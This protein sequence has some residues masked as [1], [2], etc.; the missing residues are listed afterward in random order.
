MAFNCCRERFAFHLVVGAM[1]VMVTALPLAHAKEKTL[2]PPTLSQEDLDPAAFEQSVQGNVRP[3]E[4]KF[5]PRGPSSVVWTPTSQLH[6]QGVEF[7]NDRAVGPRHLRIGFKQPQAVGSVLV[8]GGGQLSVL[9][10]DAPYP[11]NLDDD[12]QWL[13]ATRLTAKGQTE[14]AIGPDDL[15]LWDLPP[16]TKTRA[17]RFTHVVKPADRMTYGVLN[18]VCLFRDRLANVS[19]QA[20]LASS[21][22]PEALRFLQD[23]KANG[24]HTWDNGE[25]G[26][27]A[28]VSP[29]N[30]EWVLLAWPEAVRL[31]GV[32]FVW[33][34]FSAVEVAA[35]AGPAET[36]PAAAKESDWKPLRTETELASHYPARLGFQWI[37]FAEPV[38]TRALRLRFTAPAAP[39]HPH[40][41]GKVQ[42]GKRIWLDELLA[43]SPLGDKPVSTALL[44]PSESTPPPIPIRF[45]LPEAGLVT[46]VIEDE[47]GRRVRNL[48]SETPYPAGENVAYWDGSDD[49]LRDQDAA[50]HG[51]YHI[52]TRLVPTGK[53]RV[54][55]LWHKPL[56]LH[57]EMSVYTS[58][59]PAWVTEDGTGCWLT[60]HT[61]PTSMAYIPGTK[62]A[63]GKPLMMMGAFV[64]EGGHGLQWVQ[65]DGTKVGG[66]GRIGGT[67]TGAQSLAVDNGERASPDYL[68][69]AGSI[70]E[71]ELRLTAKTRNL[72]DADILKYKLGDDP[73]TKSVPASELPPRLEGFDGGEKKFV[74][75]GMAAHDGIIVCSL[76]R[77]NELLFISAADRR[78]IGKA[79]VKNPRGVAI[80]PDGC[81]LVLSGKRLLRYGPLSAIAQKLADPT[82]QTPLAPP[83]VVIEEG[84]EDPRQV[85]CRKV[86]GPN[87]Y[88]ISDRG[89]ENRVRV[90]ND[91]GQQIRVYGKPG[92]PSEGI[93]DPL[94]MNSP[95][96]LA[97]D[98]QG[99][100]W[101]AESDFYPKRVSVWAADGTL[102]KAYYGPTEYGGGG[103]LDPA[104]PQ[105]FYYR[106]LDFELDWAKGTHALKRVFWRPRPL[107]HTHYGHF[108][109]DWP[110]YP[111]GDK[112]V[113]YFTSCYTNSPTGGSPVAFLWKDT[114]RDAK[115]VAAIG[116]A[117]NWDVLTTEPFRSRWPAGLD[118]LGDRNK[119]AARFA[120]N[121]RNGDEEPQPDEV[122]IEAGD[123]A[124]V[125]IMNDLTAVFAR[126]GNEAVAIAPTVDGSTVHYSLR[127]PKTL[128]NGAQRPASSGGNQ[129]LSHPSG[130]S[131]HTNAPA[132][133]S[134]AGIGGV[135]DGQPMWSYPSPWPGLHASHE[136]AVPDRP[137]MVVGHTR[138]LGGWV[139]PTQDAAG[140]STDEAGPLFAVNGNMG[141]MYL[142]TADGLFVATLFHDI[143][144]RPNWSMPRAV[145][146]MDVTE[147]SLHDE[148]FWPSI[149]R[150]RDGKTYV[151]DGARTSLVRLDG[152]DTIQRLPSQSIEVTAKELQA[153]EEWFVQAAA[154]DPQ[155]RLRT[156]LTVTMSDKAPTVDGNLAEW[157]TGPD[158]WATIDRRGT[159]ANFNSNSKPYDASAALT[160]AGDRLYAAY[161]TSEADLLRNSGESPNA[162]FKHGGCLDLML[163]T[164]AT[165][166]P[167][168]KQPV[169]GDLRLLVTLVQ[170]K[171]RGVLY[172][173][174]VPGTT[175]PIGFSSPWRTLTLDAV[176]DV[177]PYLQFATDGKGLFEF[178]IPLSVLDWQPQ[179]GQR[180]AG[181]LGLLRGNGFETLQRIYW[182][183]KATAITSDVPSEA[184]LTPA[185]WGTLQ[186]EKKGDK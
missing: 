14:A 68:A 150:T 13:T 154:S 186:V 146:N 41:K 82:I 165:A 126:Y 78:L 42:E 140:K 83:A 51:L 116:S 112:S 61:P 76:V 104:D 77:Q 90:F 26:G 40:V 109:P 3:I 6:H 182:A 176:E 80:D 53:Y 141:N 55:G 2:L 157:P 66:Q 168:R 70:W 88:F 148:N 177:S 164:D 114:P 103:V 9:K 43:L 31:E 127:D 71:G 156:P 86:G 75:A 183:N 67:W 35:Y 134:N 16:G 105:H 22:R 149:T 19:P 15:A 158:H 166:D 4:V 73:K 52:P 130:W 119:N 111:K 132:P 100:L 138:L 79:H 135:K 163:A 170:G 64:S 95:N 25:K 59:K 99:R 74:L 87:E 131:V 7:G 143:R 179:P 27:A 32:A 129:A 173:A 171:P 142:L 118:P 29:A 37:P 159:K 145:R 11:G 174:V 128:V 8:R 180:Y 5:A 151:V 44:A 155:S 34:G 46:L 120:W 69:Y 48:V 185:R 12:T 20:L 137:G 121:D 57:Y 139:E 93:Y 160:I 85:F 106:G 92:I 96:G 125:T 1:L 28:V 122:T 181:D 136:A 63:D 36:S 110:L 45:T 115:L 24:W 33:N 175:N 84:L 184:E 47:Q 49:L 54:R 10:S 98:S 97:L 81:L 172:R 161:R 65:E 162:L 23:E 178:S 60:N 30:P 39:R 50:R 117:N 152:L 108:S 113:R 107:V 58:G 153:A 17:L 123:A 133:F 91:H 56:E 101:V 124:G 72:S 147:V 18:G 94:R 102:D 62:T 169:A 89:N 21:S 167:L 38:E 144:Q